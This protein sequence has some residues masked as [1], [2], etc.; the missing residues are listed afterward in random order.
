MPDFRHS[1]KQLPV[2]RCCELAK[3]ADLHQGTPDTRGIR[4]EHMAQVGVLDEKTYGRLLLKHRPRIIQSEEEFDRLAADLEALDALEETRELSA[5]ERELQ[6]LLA[7]L[8]T[9]FE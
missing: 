9:E 8:C 4:E 2:D 5:E 1:G 6:H 7:H 3:P